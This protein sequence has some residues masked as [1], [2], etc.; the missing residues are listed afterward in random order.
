LTWIRL[1]SVILFHLTCL[2]ISFRAVDDV[3]VCVWSDT[4]QNAHI[5]SYSFDKLEP[6][7]RG[8]RK[9]EPFTAK[10]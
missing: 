1:C 9:S 7:E 10:K 6:L 8:E 5:L 4:T 2:G 3:C